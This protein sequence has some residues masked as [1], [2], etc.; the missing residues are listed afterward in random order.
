MAWASLEVQEC[1]FSLSQGPVHQCQAGESCHGAIFGMLDTEAFIKGTWGSP[2]PFIHTTN[3]AAG[4]SGHWVPAEPAFPWSLVAQQVPATLLPVSSAQAL[5]LP[6]NL[7][8]HPWSEAEV[9]LCFTHQHPVQRHLLST[10]CMPAHKD[11]LTLG[12]I[13]S[14]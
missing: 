2:H 7:C 10:C 8:S 12:A 1:H 9:L 14:G 4:L 13:A 5:T 3:I 6:F 11:N